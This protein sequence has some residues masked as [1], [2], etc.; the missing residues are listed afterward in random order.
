MV[1][2]GVETGGSAPIRASGSSMTAATSARAS[3]T[4]PHVRLVTLLLSSVPSGSRRSSRPDVLSLPT[5]I[6]TQ[7]AIAGSRASSAS[8]GRGVAH[9]WHARTRRNGTTRGGVVD[10]W[11]ARALLLSCTCGVARE[12]QRAGA[13]RPSNGPRQRHARSRTRRGRER[14]EMRTSTIVRAVEREKR[15]WSLSAVEPI[16]ARQ[17]GT[18]HWQS[19]ALLSLRLMSCSRAMDRDRARGG[20]GGRWQRR[21]CGRRR[22]GCRLDGGRSR[23]RCLDRVDL[24]GSALG[25]ALRAKQQEASPVLDDRHRFHGDDAHVGHA[26]RR[27]QA[28]QG[29]ARR[30]DDPGRSADGKRRGAAGLQQNGRAMSRLVGLGK[31]R[32]WK[33]REPT[34]GRRMAPGAGK[35]AGRPS[36]DMLALPTCSVPAHLAHLFFHSTVPI[37]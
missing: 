8:R 6:A 28:P 18:F 1:V 12:D 13:R 33:R 22:R 9:G 35:G 3:V 5:S 30:R 31:R 26:N 11:E 10:E 21:R 37:A 25:D 4:S 15:A 16:R 20:A 17:R 2:G 14:D 29:E 27:R 24:E 34:L 23:R 7:S 32:R 19:L 36:R